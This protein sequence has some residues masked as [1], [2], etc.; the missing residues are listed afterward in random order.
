M[1]VSV[2]VFDPTTQK[3]NSISVTVD[4]TLIQDDADADLDYYVKLT[5]SAKRGVECASSIP[6]EIVRALDDLALST[7][8][9]R[10]D[11]ADPYDDLTAA[12]ED[13]VLMM[14]EGVNPGEQMCF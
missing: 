11:T 6:S 2:I 9:Y 14:I 1:A 4:F 7:R 13:Y 10:V 8:Q 12:V 5:T 3:T